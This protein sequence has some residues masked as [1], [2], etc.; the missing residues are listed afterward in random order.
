MSP[1]DILFAATMGGAKLLEQ[2]QKLGSL[3]SGKLADFVVLKGD[4]IKDLSLIR[5]VDQVWK[6][7]VR[8]IFFSEKRYLK[9]KNRLYKPIS[10]CC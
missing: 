6:G 9:K 1:R 10:P 4:P 7:G 5:S 2:E 8:Q 3:H